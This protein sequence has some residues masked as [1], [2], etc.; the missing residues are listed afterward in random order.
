[1]YTVIAYD[2]SNTFMHISHLIESRCEILRIMNMAAL[3]HYSLASFK[4]VCELTD[5]GKVICQNMHE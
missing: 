1:M 2:T 4:L 3:I 5:D